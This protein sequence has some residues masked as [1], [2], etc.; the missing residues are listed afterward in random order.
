MKTTKSVTLKLGK[1]KDRVIKEK[2]KSEWRKNKQM[3]VPQYYQ[4]P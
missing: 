2:T 4:R 1:Q 3:Q